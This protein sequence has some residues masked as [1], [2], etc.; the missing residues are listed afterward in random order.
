MLSKPKTF[1]RI[2]KVDLYLSFKIFDC[3]FAFLSH[4]AVNL[5]FPATGY[6]FYDVLEKL[7]QPE[8]KTDSQ[9]FKMKL[10]QGT[11]HLG[12]LHLF[13]LL[14]EDSTLIEL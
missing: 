8:S 11:R 2:V 5:A 12:L 3:E 6:I 9:N 4:P 1:P 7:A 14:L 10:Q 13:I